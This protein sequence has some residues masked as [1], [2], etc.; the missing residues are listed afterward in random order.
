MKIHFKHACI[1]SINVGFV[2]Q[3]MHYILCRF[4]YF[5]IA[6][7]ECVTKSVLISTMLSF[8]FFFVSVNNILS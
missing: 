4:R 7:V 1:N 6:H 2:I 5:E 3:G 8:F